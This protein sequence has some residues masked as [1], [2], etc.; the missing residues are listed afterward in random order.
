MSPPFSDFV[1]SI[2]SR[3]A[4]FRFQP[5]NQIQ[6]LFIGFRPQD[7]R[8]AAGIVRV[9]RGVVYLEGVLAEKTFFD[10]QSD[11][12]VVSALKERAGK[13]VMVF[14]Q[15]SHQAGGNGPTVPYVQ[16]RSYMVVSGLF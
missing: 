3:R 16:A 5:Q 7:E 14:G 4:V 1:G 11:A 6:S 9:S 8:V 10:P 15:V 13:Q 12:G 2:P